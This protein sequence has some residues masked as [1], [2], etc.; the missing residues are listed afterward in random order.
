MQVCKCNWL[1][2]YGVLLLGV[3]SLWYKFL[4]TT[5]L[6]TVA[7]RTQWQDLFS[8]TSL[9]AQFVYFPRCLAG[10]NRCKLVTVSWQE[11]NFFS[12]KN[13]GW[14]QSCFKSNS[15]NT[16]NTYSSVP[17]LSFK[18]SSVMMMV[19]MPDCFFY[20]SLIFHPGLPIQRVPEGPSPSREGWAPLHQTSHAGVKVW[21]RLRE[22]EPWYYG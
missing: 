12:K 6:T 8:R 4:K 13:F 21:R 9:L 22:A 17:R 7:L 15:A 20:K 3:W 11:P 14:K 16:S 5:A 1:F 18:V 10:F 2:H 19:I